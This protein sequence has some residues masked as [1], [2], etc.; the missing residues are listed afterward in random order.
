LQLKY[1][2]Y[3]GAFKGWSD[4]AKITGKDP[5]KVTTGDKIKGALAG[6]ASAMTF[7]LVKPQT[8]LKMGERNGKSIT[9]YTCSERL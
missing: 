6:A 7:G 2:L 5:S 3:G 4:A 8:M 9:I 1:H